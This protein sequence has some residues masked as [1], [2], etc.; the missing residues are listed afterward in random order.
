MPDFNALLVPDAYAASALAVATAFSALAILLLGAG[1]LWRGRT[2]GASTLFCVLAT[3]TAGWLG[4]WA[5]M[6]ASR[7]ADVA[8]VW[9][10]LGYAFGV[11]IPA[12]MFH[13]AARLIGRDGS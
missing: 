2:R 12:V 4:A 8:L 11:M 9:A 13:F 6:Y 7:T 1:V 10:R 5:V 3:I